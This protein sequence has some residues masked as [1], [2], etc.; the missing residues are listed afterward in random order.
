M[1]TI[2]TVVI[3]AGHAGLAVSKLLTDACREH[4]VLDRGRIGNRWRTERWDSL[5]L[6]T[7]SWM[8]RLP[9]W[10]YR[11][12][13]PDGYLSVGSFIGYLEAY[14]ASF[15]APVVDGAT[16]HE[17][18]AATGEPA[19]RRYRVV[20]SRGTWHTRHVVI[21]T[22]PHGTPYVPAG[23]AGLDTARVDLVTSNNYRNPS[24][25]GSGGVLVV[26]ASASGVQIADE[27]NRAGRE[28]TL[29][30]GTHTRMPRRH[31]GLDIFWWLENTGRL[32]RTIDEM[33]D[34]V[35]ARAETSLQLVG[36]DDRVRATEDL[37][38]GRLQEHGVRLVGRL[39]AV[40]GCTARF[41]SDLAANVAAADATLAELLESFDRFVERVGLGGQLWDGP[42]PRPVAIGPARTRVDLRAEGIGT[43]LLA[44]GYRQHHPWL[45]LPITDAD[46]TVR[47]RR[48]VTPAEG[49]YVVGQRFQH[50]R[51][52]GQIDGARHD[53]RAV[54][55]HLLAASG[56]PTPAT[57]GAGARR[58]EPAA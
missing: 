53:A 33:D 25:L 36:R 17:V 15:D 1:T 4:V 41:R 7:P 13:D 35:A 47:Q 52:S 27:L 42:R 3:G 2:D 40:E 11:G 16:V 44:A 39:D 22:G 57:A 32:A 48:G 30:V 14:A 23:L 51:D 38:L 56:T 8:T 49:V 12:P 9:G 26:G 19:A 20:T 50:R 55:D 45:R 29:A 24:R 31:R 43:V 10:G 28:V 6:L 54:V 58:R 5:H 34:P 37:D 18:S 21:A 46:G